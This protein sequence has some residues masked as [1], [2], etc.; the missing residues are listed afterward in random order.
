MF[1][2]NEVKGIK[3]LAHDHTHN[4]NSPNNLIK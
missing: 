2:D 4:F 1:A 3:K